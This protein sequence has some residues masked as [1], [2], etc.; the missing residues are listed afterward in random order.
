MRLRALAELDAAI[1]SGVEVGLLL[2]Q[3]VGYFRDVMALVGWLQARAT[4]LRVAL[5]G[6]RSCWKSVGNSGIATI[7]AISQ[8]LDQSSARMRVSVHGR[9]LVEMAIVRICQLGELDELAT[10]VAEIRGTLA[11]ASTGRSTGAEQ[12]RTASQPT[13]AT[14]RPADSSKKNAEPAPPSLAQGLASAVSSAIAAVAAAGRSTEP[15][16]QRRR[17]TS[18]I[19]PMVK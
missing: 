17:P 9:T 3:L 5:A 7:L 13:A 8:I 4:A 15:R 18:A 1:A 6:G 16:R 10:L 2:D 12:Q 11:D 14:L 19:E